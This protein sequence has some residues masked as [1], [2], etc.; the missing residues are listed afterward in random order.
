LVKT[1]V[2]IVEMKTLPSAIQVAKDDI[3]SFN[4]REG[5]VYHEN[6]A[7]SLA[8]MLGEP[9]I[10]SHGSVGLDET[11][12]WYLEFPALGGAL[13]ADSAVGTLLS[14]LKLHLVGTLGSPKLSAPAL[15]A[16]ADWMQQRRTEKR[17]DPSKPGLL[18]GRHKSNES[19]PSSPATPP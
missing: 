13:P 9:L 10:R 19:V 14:Q 3:V 7:F 17:D 5:R 18:P 1:L 8:P 2:A 16:L 6:L 11:L 4:M 12:D 15:K